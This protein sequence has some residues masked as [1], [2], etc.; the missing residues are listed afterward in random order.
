M[1]FCFLVP[2][3]GVEPT[4]AEPESDILS[5]ELRRRLAKIEFLGETQIVFNI[6]VRVLRLQDALQILNLNLQ[7]QV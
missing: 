2:A 3:A 5:I 1:S 7:H 4:S 6:N